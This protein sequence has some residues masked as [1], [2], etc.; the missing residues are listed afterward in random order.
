MRLLL[1]ELDRMW[2]RRAVVLLVLA[3][4]L[5][6]ALLAGTAAWDTRPVSADERAA[7]EVQARNA[8]EDPLFKKDLAQC[9]EDPTSFLGSDAVAADCDQVL[10]PRP[11]DFMSRATLDLGQTLDGRGVAVVLLVTA[12]LIIAGATFAGGDWAT[13]SISNQLLFRPRRTEVWLAK[14]GAV[15]LSA[16]VVSAV[17]IG[18]FWLA[19]YLTADS[20]GIATPGSVLHDIRW[21]TGR[22]AVLATA[23]ALGGYA[24]TMLLRSTVGTLALLFAYAVVGEALVA[25]LPVERASQWS[26]SN[27]VFAWVDDG[28]RVFDPDRV[29]PPG[30]GGCIQSYILGLEHGAAYLG[31]LLLV[32]VVVSVVAFRRR[33]VP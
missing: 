8:A 1:V 27:N 24:L 22:G 18:G 9:R 5:L 3:A 26:L 16:L 32:A 12:L 33:D 10:T 30:R 4:A 7:A 19:L 15:L 14:A 23:G 29:C 25:A 17:V 20:R 6:T 28:T 21:T 13:G 31:A 11:E 2:S